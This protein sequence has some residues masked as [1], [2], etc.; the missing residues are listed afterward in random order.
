MADSIDVIKELREKTSAGVMECKRAL[1]ESKGDLNEA[2][3]ILK[4][5][6]QAK[7]AKK[8]SRQ[9]KEG[10]IGVYI[11]SDSKLGVLVEIGCETD[12]V[13][14]NPEFKEFAKNIAMQIAACN[15]EYI[16][17]EEISDEVKKAE[18]DFIKSEI[19][20]TSKPEKVAQN[21]IEGKLEKFYEKSCLLSQVYIK[22]EEVKVEELV[23]N[24]ISKFGENIKISRFV[25]FKVGE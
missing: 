21:I 10:C 24:T 22:D 18:I 23:N 14:K 5:K 13:A 1:E 2:V 9:I 6:G 4:A 25:R 3:N 15:P 8:S 16:S 12:F 19:D 11:H 7:A 20:L 17:K